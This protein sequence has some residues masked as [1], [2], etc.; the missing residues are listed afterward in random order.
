MSE[1][2]EC[3]HSTAGRVVAV[4]QEQ[5]ARLTRSNPQTAAATSARIRQPRNRRRIARHQLRRA[6]LRPVCV[7]LPRWVDHVDGPTLLGLRVAL[8]LSTASAA[9]QQRAAGLADRGRNNATRTWNSALARSKRACDSSSAHCTR[10]ERCRRSRACRASSGSSVHSDASTQLRWA[11]TK[12]GPNASASER[13]RWR[14]L[15]AASQTRWPARNKKS[16]GSFF[17]WLKTLSPSLSV[18]LP[19]S[20]TTAGSVRAVCRSGC[21]Q[22]QRRGSK[23]ERGWLPKH[24]LTQRTC[25][26]FAVPTRLQLWQACTQ[27]T[28]TYARPTMP[29][30]KQSRS[31]ADK[32]RFSVSGK[33][34]RWRSARS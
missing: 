10:H 15:H 5:A 1:Q 33:L 20:V 7:R 9:K 29:L 28:T 17:S 26:H 8:G 32:R 4:Q 3:A 21:K 23:G 14:T 13:H 11:G 18:A 12:S 30:G 16:H 34:T 2:P 22:R 24:E 27:A 6:R 25:R 19:T 31:A